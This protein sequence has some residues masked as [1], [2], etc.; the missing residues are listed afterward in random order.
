MKTLVRKYVLPLHRWTALT[1]GLVIL[2]IAA[3]GAS[4]AFRTELEPALNRDLYTV[5]ACDTRQALDSLVANAMAA[6]PGGKLDYIRVFSGKPGADRTPA[7]I[8][9]FKDEEQTTAYLNPCSGEVIGMR[10]RF[11]GLFGTLEKIHRFRFM[12]G[13]GLVVGS[14]VLTFVLVLL[15]GGI[16]LWWPARGGW[17][18]ALKYD[19]KLPKQARTMSLHKTI[20]VYASLILLLSAFT[21]LPLS[22]EWFRA[23]MYGVVGST[24]PA[25]TPKIKAE[26][27]AAVLPLEQLWQRSQAHMQNPA[28]ALLHNPA[29]SPNKAM[30]IY[31]IAQDAPHPNARTMLYLDPYTGKTVRFTPYEKNS[32]GHKLYF[33]A[34]SWH[35]GLYGGIPA[36]LLLLSGALALLYLGYSGI[37]MYLRRQSRV[38]ANAALQKRYT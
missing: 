5:P 25:K 2:I 16:A 12:E 17:K 19:A 23:G 38:R 32:A 15:G 13:G 36:Q 26:P 18:R 11:S 22:F 27:G 3:T 24:L 10:P 37:A 6:R 33:W 1:I 35:M 7:S 34:L 30:D 9:R 21:G 31:M 8:V 4:M 29:E 20:G 14:I 28:E